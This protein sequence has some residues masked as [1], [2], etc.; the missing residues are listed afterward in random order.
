VVDRGGL[1]N[2]CGPLDHRGFESHPLRLCFKSACDFPIGSNPPLTGRFAT[3]SAFALNQPVTS[4]IGSNLPLT[5]RF[6]TLSAFALIRRFQLH[7]S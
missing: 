2:R 4:P 5:G 3:L 7:Y 6:A 1:E